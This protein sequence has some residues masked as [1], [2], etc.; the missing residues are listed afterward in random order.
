MLESEGHAPTHNT[1]QEIAAQISRISGGLKEVGNRW[2]PRFLTRH[3]K[4]HS[5]LGKSINALRIQ[6]TN[7]DDLRAWFSLFRRVLT[8]YKVA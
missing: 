2:L 7:P 5:K 3:P 6:S 4:L 1:V 8:E